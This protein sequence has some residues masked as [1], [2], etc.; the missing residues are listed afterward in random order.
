[1]AVRTMMSQTETITDK[2]F[3]GELKPA[4]SPAMIPWGGAFG[5][6][7]VFASVYSSIGAVCE[8]NTDTISAKQVSV[9]LI[10]GGQQFFGGQDPQEPT[11]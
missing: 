7:G 10:S 3:S 4:P 5:A 8:G 1:M 6:L 2:T 9:G 11:W